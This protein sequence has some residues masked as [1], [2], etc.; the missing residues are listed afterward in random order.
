MKTIYRILMSI[1][2]LTLLYITITN[3][4]VNLIV[5]LLLLIPLYFIHDYLYQIEYVIYIYL[6]QVLGTT[7]HFYNLPFYDKVMHFLSG[8]VFVCM[9]YVFLQKYIPTKKILYLMINCVEMSIAFLW[10]IF[11]YCGLILFNYDASHH[12]TTGVHDTMQDMIVSLIG[13]LII[14]YFIYKFPSYMCNLYRLPPNIP[15]EASP[16]QHT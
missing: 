5:S 11:E 6:T 2:L 13:G 12:Y 9:G 7:C 10:E 16:Q 8:M 15:D 4:H 3:F 14:T 1:Y